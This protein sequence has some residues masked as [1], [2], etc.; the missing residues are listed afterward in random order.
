MLLFS[1][2][3][4]SEI[5][6]MLGLIWPYR[7][8]GAIIAA[9]LK[10]DQIR[11][12]NDRGIPII[13]YNN[14][15]T[16]AGVNLEPDTVAKLAEI[17]NVVGIKDSSGDM[18]YARSVVALSKSLDVFPSNEACLLDARK[19]DFA[20][21]IS[22]TANTNAP[23]CGRAFRDGDETAHKTAVAIRKLFD[24]K[25]LV[26]GVK[27]LTAHILDDDAI[28]KFLPPFDALKAADRDAVIDGYRKLTA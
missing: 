23:Y 28:A 12:F 11:Q 25:P 16:C 24:G 5:G 26:P 19:G 18:P 21:C 13:L 4:E 27:A 1:L 2:A 17:P 9:R 3:S 6:E 8:D 14:P 7:V 22:A 15:A 20:G 10:D